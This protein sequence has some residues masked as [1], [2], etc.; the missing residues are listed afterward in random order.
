MPGELKIKF[1]QYP[2]L[3]YIY[4]Q[5]KCGTSV[6]HRTLTKS[7]WQQVME[8]PTAVARGVSEPCTTLHENNEISSW[9]HHPLK[10]NCRVSAVANSTTRCVF[11]PGHCVCFAYAHCPVA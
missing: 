4:S 9:A 7:Q 8:Q 2:R 3:R 6:D 5:C 10:A 11:A 1:G